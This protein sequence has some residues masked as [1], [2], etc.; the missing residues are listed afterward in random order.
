MGRSGPQS[1]QSLTKALKTRELKQLTYSST[2]DVLLIRCSFG[3]KDRQH[4]PN[5]QNLKNYISLV[6]RRKKEEKNV[7]KLEV[8]KYGTNCIHMDLIISGFEDS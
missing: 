3:G 2:D 7:C 6:L 1:T 5:Q 8:T 4:L